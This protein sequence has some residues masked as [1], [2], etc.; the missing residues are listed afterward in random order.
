MALRRK[1]NPKNDEYWDSVVGKRSSTH[2][3]KS[4]TKVQAVGM[5]PDHPTDQQ[6][7]NSPLAAKWA[8]ARIKERKQLEKYGVFTKIDK[9]DIPKES[10]II[11]TKWVYTI[12]RKLDRSIEKYK[13]RKVGRGFSQEE[14]V[15]YDADQ[16]FAQMM[17]PETFKILLVIAL[18]RN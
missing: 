12:K 10:K 3:R 1:Q 2:E 8:K 7:R 11:D 17:R 9:A 16:T 14:G 6:A 15:S 5:D 13:A 4:T 18:Y